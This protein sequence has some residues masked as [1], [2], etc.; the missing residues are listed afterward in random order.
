MNAIKILE[1]QIQADIDSGKITSQA[2]VARGIGVEPQEISN[3]K[4]RGRIPVEKQKLLCNYYGW[5]LDY[6]NTGKEPSYSGVNEPQAD[7]HQDPLM[8]LSPTTQAI[9]KLIQEYEDQGI[10][11]P[12]EILE[13]FKA[14]LKI[15]LSG[16]VA[17]QSQKA[18]V[19][20]KLK[21]LAHASE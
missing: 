14:Y 18:K 4:A 2:T 21:D 5:S 20:Q 17:N 3:W 11:V 10:E 19:S 9:T 7:Y 13:E 6:L 15:R 1:K 16:L 12:T 8:Q